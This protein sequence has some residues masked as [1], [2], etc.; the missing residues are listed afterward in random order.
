MHKVLSRI[1]LFSISWLANPLIIAHAGDNLIL[2]T[3]SPGNIFIQ[4]GS[5]KQNKNAQNFKRLLSEKTTYPVIIRDIGAYHVV[6]IGPIDTAG[7]AS[8]LQNSLHASLSGGKPQAILLKTTTHQPAKAAG[9][10]PSV[11]AKPAPRKVLPISDN[12][13]PSGYLPH[14]Y[15]LSIGP[16]FPINDHSNQTLLI[17]SD[18]EKT[19]TAGQYQRIPFQGEI[20][21]GWQKTFPRQ[22]IGQV[23][24]AAGASSNVSITGNIWED[25]NANFNNFSYGYLLSHQQVM[26]QGGVWAS[27]WPIIPYVRAGVGA[28]FNKAQNYL[29]SP[30]ITEEVAAPAFNAKRTIAFTYMVGAGLQKAINTHWQAS[31]GYAFSDWGKSQFNKATGETL[32]S[33]PSMSHYYVNSLV[34]QLSYLR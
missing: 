15:T 7:E 25:A 10:H 2:K 20:F 8:A 6:R 18:L 26:I 21:A 23:G 24:V 3:R 32:V 29:I 12:T 13:P 33:A 31:I 22:L 14:V 17:E 5:F 9:L 1:I 16:G 34:F 4:Y 27:Y 11:S 19:Y 28:G 30:I